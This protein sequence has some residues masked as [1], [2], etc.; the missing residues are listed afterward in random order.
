M[1]WVRCSVPEVLLS[2]GVC[3]YVSCF[4][5]TSDHVLQLWSYEFLH[6]L[7]ELWSANVLFFVVS[8]DGLTIVSLFFFFFY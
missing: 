6:V 2:M 4:V 7:G 3:V 1:P 5:T 8:F